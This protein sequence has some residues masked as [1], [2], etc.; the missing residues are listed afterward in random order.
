M[1][2]R[3][4]IKKIFFS[5]QVFEKS[6]LITQFINK[7][8]KHGVILFKYKYR[9]IVYYNH[10]IIGV[11]Y[12]NF[13]YGIFSD[14]VE[15]VPM[16]EFLKYETHSE[17]NETFLLN[18]EPKEFAVVSLYHRVMP[19][20][21]AQIKFLWKCMSEGFNPNKDEPADVDYINVAKIK[22]SGKSLDK[23]E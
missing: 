22:S 11:W 14:A 9:I 1:T 10:R 12:S 2:R 8:A 21:L 13:P 16:E 23:S 18:G 19:S 4:M 3:K 6:K 20:K 7:L 5:S 15:Y 17:K